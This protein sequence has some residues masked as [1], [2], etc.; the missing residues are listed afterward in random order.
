MHRFQSDLRE[1]TLW[2]TKV[3]VVL[4]R[5]DEMTAAAAASP[6][7]MDADGDQLRDLHK[8]FTVRIIYDCTIFIYISFNRPLVRTNAIT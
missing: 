6:A 7:A 8:A 5:H 3:E 4:K 1:L 2:S